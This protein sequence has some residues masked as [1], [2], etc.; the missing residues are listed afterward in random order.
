[1][2]VL[3]LRVNY[4]TQGRTRGVDTLD[5][6]DAHSLF[7]FLRD[8]KETRKEKKQYANGRQWCQSRQPFS[9]AAGDLTLPPD[10]GV[11]SDRGGIEAI[12]DLESLSRRLQTLEG[13]FRR[14]KVLAVIACIGVAALMLMGQA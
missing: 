13:R 10:S 3:S 8:K 12:T 4:Y 6:V 9:R 14:I 2:A 1:M 5:G 11:T 7:I